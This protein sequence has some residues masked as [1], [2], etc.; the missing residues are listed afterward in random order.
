MLNDLPTKA[1]VP[2]GEPTKA[3]MLQYLTCY[4]CKG[5][6]RDAHTLN[7]CMCTYCKAC[8]HHYYQENGSRTKCPSCEVDLGGK[9]LEAVV[10]DMTLQSIVDWLIPDFKMRDDKLKCELLATKQAKR[11]VVKET[12]HSKVTAD[13]DFEFKLLP[14]PDEDKHLVMEPLPKS[15]KYASAKKTILTIKKHI[16]NYTGESIDNIEILCKNFEVADSYTLDFVKRTKW[17][18]EGAK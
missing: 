13:I 15:L 2:S 14:F 18:K 8:I 4:L 16:S 7:E 3:D 6:Y 5:V 11:G 10:R 9:P 1:Y 12:H 17:H